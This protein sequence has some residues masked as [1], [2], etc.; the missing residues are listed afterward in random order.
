[1]YALYLIAKK[2]VKLFFKNYALLPMILGVP[3][4]QIYMM[5]SMM[6]V[7]PVIGDLV[8]GFVTMRILSEVTSGSFLDFF[9]ASTMVQFVFVSAVVLNATL[10]TERQEN[11]YTR[12][13]ASPMKKWKIVLGNLIG[14]TIVLMMVSGAIMLSSHFAFGI[15]WGNSITNII[16][17]TL[18]TAL[19]SNS[20]SY[21][22]S[23]FF[24]SSKT[25]GGVMSLIMILMT[26]MSGGFSGEGTL[27]TLRLF[28]FNK[29]AVDSFLAVIRNQPN[30]VLFSNIAGLMTILTISFIVSTI[31]YERRDLNG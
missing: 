23:S 29:Y 9:A 12:M 2:N 10:I 17:V 4:F 30:G 7:E 28:T 31:I 1:M 20:F 3:I 19:A 27:Q 15:S 21:F 25:A 18:L 13:M 14:N 24:K 6:D 8:Q 26:F 11:T 22:I 5:T 16:V